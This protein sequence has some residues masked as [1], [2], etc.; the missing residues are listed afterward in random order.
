MHLCASKLVTGSSLAK[1]GVAL[2]DRLADAL[3]AACL[4]DHAAL[5]C[6]YGSRLE[7]G[8]A[9]RALICGKGGSLSINVACPNRYSHHSLLQNGIILSPQTWHTCR[10]PR[11]PLQMKCTHRTLSTSRRSRSCSDR[12]II[13]R[14]ANRLSRADSASTE[15]VRL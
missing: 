7:H 2:C 9:H 5:D 3:D 10:A 11:R 6:N 8:R 14:S 1:R 13:A 12:R 4:R 15:F